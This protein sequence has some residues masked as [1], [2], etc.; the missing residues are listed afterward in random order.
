MRRGECA[1]AAR[2]GWKNGEDKSG[3]RIY[4]SNP[5]EEENVV[6]RDVLK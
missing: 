5:G 4:A 3:K 1:E 2:S 6:K